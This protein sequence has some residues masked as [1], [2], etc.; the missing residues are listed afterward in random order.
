MYGR[1]GADKLNV[2]LA[3]FLVFLGIVSIFVWGYVRL[4]VQIIEFII[5]ALF[6]F[7]FL[8]RDISRR[9]TE[10]DKFVKISA[11]IEKIF[12]LRFKQLSDKDYKYFKCPKCSASLRVP[13]RRGNIT[14]T[15]PVCRNKFDKKT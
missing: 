9:R 10:N 6:L 13:K 1:Y 3:I 2:F 11:P 14:V 4:A 8:S 15:C 7:R 5:F 12:K